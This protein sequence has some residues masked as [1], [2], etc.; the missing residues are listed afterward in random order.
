MLY[1]ERANKT[2]INAILVI[3]KQRVINI[4]KENLSQ[5][6]LFGSRARGD[7]KQDSDID[8]LIVLKNV[9]Q[10]KNKYEKMIN[11]VSDLCLEY[12]FL[13]SCVYIS[14]SQFKSEKSPLMINIH[15]EGIFL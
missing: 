1:K 11:L 15:K 10:D 14:E 8:I 9:N 4:Y 13:I 3:F 7:A 2:Q 12:N 5:L 6:I